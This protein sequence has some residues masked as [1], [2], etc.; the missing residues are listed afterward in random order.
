MSEFSS[1]NLLIPSMS[2]HDI[3]ILYGTEGLRQRF[4]IECGVFDS[5]ERDLLSRSLDYAT[6]L[7]Q[8]DFRG[9]DPY[10]NHPLRVALRIMAHYEIEESK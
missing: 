10:I 8:E 1:K 7:H 5:S 4:E 3:S 9:S 2:I 6:L